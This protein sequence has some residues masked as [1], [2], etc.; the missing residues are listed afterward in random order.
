MKPFMDTDFLLEN[1]TARVLYHRYAARMPIIDYHCHINPA[2]IAAN[3]Q[4]DNITQVWLGGD[5]YKWRMIRS[6]GVPEEEITG[7]APDRV[8]FQRF[9]EALPR[10][11]GNP[12]YHWTHL[13]LKRYFGYEGVLNGDTAEEVWQLC[14][15]ALQQPDMTVR[16][17]IRQSG[18]KVI[19][20]TDDPVDDL[21]YHRQIAADPTCADIR[22][23]PSYRPDKA[24][25]IH[26]AG[27]ADY[28]RKLGEASGVAIATVADVKAALAAAMDRFEAL[29]CKASDHGID[30]V[31]Y[32]PATDEQVEA[33]FAKGMAGAPVTE[34]EMEQYATAILLFLG[35]EYARRGW[36]MQLHYGALRNTN[37]NQFARL[38]PDTG[39]DCISTR[40]CGEGITGLLNALEV[41]GELP[42]TI[43]YSL[44][45]ADNEL[46][47][48]ILGCFQGTEAAGKIQHGSAWWFNDNKTGMEKQLTDLANLSLLG[49]FIGMLTD[50]RSFL[51]YTRHEYFRR[52]LCNLIGRWVENGEYPADMDTLGTLVQDICY[53]NAARYFGF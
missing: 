5:H 30:Y 31:M 28:I 37:Q 52:I 24:I 2:E 1:E 20:T 35:R 10:A 53:N 8:K 32:R 51:S 14:N 50:S 43:L 13:E 42:K 12:M 3:R 45:P 46:L 17:L 26:K 25:N 47:G 33:V 16:G 15:R 27:F 9:A 18:V 39:Y 6:N 34:E 38:G 4:F 19:G 21:Q 7:N 41:T 40:S 49:N 23:V 29:G 36:V 44:N 48:T 22:V 11:I